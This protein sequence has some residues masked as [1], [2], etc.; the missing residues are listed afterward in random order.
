MSNAEIEDRLAAG[1]PMPR[2][3]RAPRD[4]REDSARRPEGE[5]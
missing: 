1:E 4:D 3:R 2:V 5:R